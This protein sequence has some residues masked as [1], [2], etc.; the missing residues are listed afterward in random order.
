MDSKRLNIA[1][2]ASELEDPFGRDLCE[3][4]N[5]AAKQI[6]A[7]LFIFP[8]K[9]IDADYNDVYRT[10]YDY[11]FNSLFDYA[12][13]NDIDVFVVCMGT[14]ASNISAERRLEFLM[15]FDKPVIVV[16]A[17][18]EGFPNVYYDNRTGLKAGVRH[19]I[20]EHGRKNI[21]FV[22]GP[23]T[24]EDSRER[25]AAYREALEESGIAYNENYV[26]YGNF[27][28]YSEETVYSLMTK[29][30]NLDAVVFANDMMAVGGYRVFKELG[31]DVG[32]DISVLGF[33]DSA[34]ALTLEPNL[35]T[36][37]VDPAELAYQA[38]V[39]AEA[40]LNGDINEIVIPSVPVIRASCGCRKRY[41]ADFEIEG[42]LMFDN[43]R[44]E[45]VLESIYEYLLG[46]N[47]NQPGTKALKISI[48]EFYT[49]LLQ[50]I[51]LAEPHEQEFRRLFHMMRN[52]LYM[53]L[54]PYTN[55]S[56]L[57]RLFG[58]IYNT[59]R[60]ALKDEKSLRLLNENYYML[61]ADI[62][63]YQDTVF[64]SKET[65][66]DILNYIATSF[67]RDIMNFTI[68]DDRAYFSI[69][70]KLSSLHYRSAYLCLF[71]EKVIRRK[72]E[73]CEIPKDILLKT[74]MDRSEMGWVEADEQRISMK[75]IVTNLYRERQDRV[76]VMVNLLFSTMEQYGLFIS[77]IEEG[78]IHN[79]V[80][81]SY[82]MSAAVKTVEL[83]KENESMMQQLKNNIEE[84]KE[85][86]LILDEISKSDEL[87]QI[88]NRRGF[89][90]MVQRKISSASNRGRKAFVIYA[91]MNNLK[92]INDRF[93]H[94]EGDYSLKLIAEILKDSFDE[95]S[96]IG[97][98][99]GD[100]F[101]AF[102]YATD[103]KTPKTIRKK[104]SQITKE[105][106]EGNGKPYYVSMSV[107]VC[108]LKC[109]TDV[110][111]K[112]L[113][114]KADVDLYIEKKHKR[115]NVLKNEDEAI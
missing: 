17:K 87:T 88:Y 62:V 107:G 3:G 9:Y 82:Q 84:I 97:R 111:L 25:L 86:N 21:G 39:N 15:Q 51:V 94:E 22:S 45:E 90:T 10:G 42:S 16:A 38:I 35:S 18:T 7:N 37:K 63:A 31:L 72:N 103:E 75:N 73:E 69:M 100:E 105:R 1:L 12:Q 34:C 19:L 46:R 43:E 53:N 110:E 44:K 95:K 60:G 4:A 32:E 112:D 78:Y 68:G 64:I 96:I 92:I 24:S 54:E 109:G 13:L 114:D 76:T 26:V 29:H 108:E 61:Y 74:Y 27:T 99:G 65:E 104:I 66:A 28:E 41:V 79:S 23:A 33:D 98:F 71:P 89:L 30:P 52:I 80:P 6:D 85:K 11:Q 67:T 83:L 91:D 40:F 70:E 102:T 48:S 93:G 49:F 115:S 56:K 14:I 81:I 36:I 106:N 20:E 101:V 113:M 2:L 50:G 47:M 8:G 55:M 5:A 59:L 57:I 77:E 58:S